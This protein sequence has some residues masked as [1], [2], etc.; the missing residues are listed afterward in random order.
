MRCTIVVTE[1][2]EV[3]VVAA[4]NRNMTASYCKQQQQEQPYATT[5]VFGIQL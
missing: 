1:G 5:H 4:A 3:M 2:C